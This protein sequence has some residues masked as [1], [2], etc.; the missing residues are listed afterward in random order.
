MSSNLARLLGLHSPRCSAPEEV[1]NPL[2]VIGSSH[3]YICVYVLKGE[4][5]EKKNDF[6]FFGTVAATE[7]NRE[8]M[9]RT[10]PL[11]A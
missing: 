10:I 7:A 4:Y 2:E 9:L 1:Q 5:R 11:C 6:I 8:P 3:L